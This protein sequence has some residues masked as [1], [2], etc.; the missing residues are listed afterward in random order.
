LCGL[1]VFVKVLGRS[2]V[3]DPTFGVLYLALVRPVE[4]VSFIRR[5]F[6]A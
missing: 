1:T 3:Q 4:R 5:S 2:A 6:A